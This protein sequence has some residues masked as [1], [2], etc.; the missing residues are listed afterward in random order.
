MRRRRN[1]RKGIGLIAI[2]AGVVIL[3]AMILPVGFWW[4]M[5]AVLLIS[6]GIWYNRC[7]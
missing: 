6:V 2:T 1:P 3:L 7:R 4:F 5:L